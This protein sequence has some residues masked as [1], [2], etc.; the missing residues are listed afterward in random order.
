MITRLST[1]LAPLLLFAGWSW[2]S[3]Q[4]AVPPIESTPL[5]PARDSASFVLLSPEQ[6]GVD[7]VNPIDIRHPLKRLYIN[8]FACGGVAIGDVNG[9]GKPDL[10]LTNGPRPNGLYLQTGDLSF[11]ETAADSGV[12]APDRWSTGCAMIDIDG[13]GDLDLY[14][15]CY[16]APNLLFLNE[17]AGSGGVPRFREAARDFGLDIVDA[18][19][20]PSFCDYDRDGDI[21]LFLQ[22]NEFKPDGGMPQDP[23]VY[24]KDG[25]YYVL[26]EF[27]KFY[28]I[29][30]NES[31]NPAFVNAGRANY[32]MRNEGPDADGQIRF[33]DVS[34]A[35]GIAGRGITNSA[36]WWDY[37]GD[38]WMDLHEANDFRGADKLYHNNGDGTFTDVIRFT[39]PHTTWFSMGADFGDINNDGRF[40]LLVTDM[41]GTTHYASKSTMGEMG[42]FRQFLVSAV[43]RQYMRN[44]L[45]LG[46]GT[47]RF[48]EVAFMAGVSSSDWTWAVKFADFDNDSLLDVFISNGVAR[49]FND[50]DNAMTAKRQY[51]MTEWDYWETFPPRRERNIAYR[52]LGDVRFADAAEAWGIDHVGMSYAAATGDLDG[53]GD[54]DLVVANLDE[55][56]SIYRNDLGL[57]QR[58]AIRLVGS[59]GNTQGIGTKATLRAGGIQQIRQLMPATGFVSSNEPLLHFGLG[60]V[61]QVESLI[62][63][64]PS[65]ARQE[66]TGLQS[67]RLYTIKEP[68]TAP[69]AITPARNPAVGENGPAP[70]FAFSNRIK[71][72]VHRETDYDDYARQP[73]LP[74]RHSLLGP[75]LAVGDIDGDG[76][77]DLFHGGAKGEAGRLLENRD[78]QFVVRPAPALAA[79][80]GREDL[81]ALFF[82]ADRD[83]DLDLYVVS[84]SVE[85]PPQD[86]SLSDRLYLNNSKGEFED[87]SYALPERRDSG[88]CVVAAD[89]DRDGDLDL[90]VGARVIP[91]AY[92]ETPSSILL[93]NHSTPGA[94]KFLE[95]PERVAPGLRDAGLV[96]AALWTDVDDDGWI[97]LLVACEW[98]PLRLFSNQASSSGNER[99]LIERTVEAGLAE[100]PGWW[101]GLAAHDLDH[102]GDIDFVATNF[103]L[104]TQYKASPEK[105][106][107]L[108]YGDM[109]GSGKRNI[110]EAKFE[111]KSLFPRRGLSCSSHAMPSVREKLKTFHNFASSTLTEVYS[112]DRIS[113]AFRLEAHYL[114]HIAFLNDGHGV[115]RAVPLPRLA[116][117]A[118]AFGVAITDFDADGHAD[119]VLAQNF[120]APQPETGH[121]D[122]G[123]S[124]VLRGAGDGSFSAIGPRTSGI[125]VPTDAKGLVITDLDGNGRPDLLIA[126]NNGPVYPFENRL[127]A[128]TPFSVRLQGHPGNP[129]CV[130]ARV[131]L[132][133][134]KFP[135]QTA[136][137]SAGSGYLSQS[138]PVFFFGASPDPGALEV[139]VR[140]P[141]GRRSTHAAQLPAAAITLTEPAD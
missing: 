78:G 7:F 79:H 110:V 102:D 124:L 58:I 8:G 46:T 132:R 25:K 47:P 99:V 12:D 28:D 71:D 1:A 15:G 60:T 117:T 16:D 2:T 135:V 119:L 9:D 95:A 62:L 126:T 136:E 138:S 88:S 50:S 103:G 67:G 44:A 85:C 108:F 90:F 42:Q 113:A 22:C 72:A 55:P 141:N 82:D 24:Q 14:V 122:G 125:L 69:A 83:G 40:D 11:T 18:S 123:V 94:P 91:G 53:D 112:E 13:D 30:I 10:Y 38:G 51:E 43:P 29:R 87:A 33:S 130:G 105:P 39:M 75:G 137:V 127:I 101:N 96:T 4:A 73:L 129:T 104:N 6:T 84:G 52:N 115:F 131:T 81:G 63:E 31:G 74:Y 134:E 54:L 77:E 37:N 118:P 92:P 26:P 111:G 120:F 80:A 65:G 21:D 98:G 17:G 19:L 128:G 86:P 5:R 56:V 139:E 20:M 57:G 121:M 34:A 97:D 45:F 27:E 48:L 106:E 70:M 76:D 3:S 68:S 41:A 107:L 35:A 109:D 114:E 59:S 49:S 100:M 36:T 133:G 116:Q 61:S 66:F 93:I 64:W 140:W 23:P 89:F 32:L